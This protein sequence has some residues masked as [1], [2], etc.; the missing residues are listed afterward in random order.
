MDQ[1][2]DVK[3]SYSDILAFD[4]SV[5]LPF[6]DPINFLNPLN[7]LESKKNSKKSFVPYLGLIAEG[8]HGAG[9]RRDSAAT[10]VVAGGAGASCALV[11]H[12]GRGSV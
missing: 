3:D 9:R 8:P 4:M 12:V 7:P 10:A 5:Y 1:Y 2:C 11:A 6:G